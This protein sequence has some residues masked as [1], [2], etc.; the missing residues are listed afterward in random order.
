MKISTL[1]FTS[2]VASAGGNTINNRAAANKQFSI[3][4]QR[5]SGFKGVDAPAAYIN[6]HLKYNAVLPPALQK[7]I[8]NNPLLNSKFSALGLDGKLLQ[9]F[10]TC[11][12]SANKRRP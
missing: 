10:M 4:Q 9:W 11:E 5:N 7:I 12:V 3:S 8:L 2:S 1:L 6:L